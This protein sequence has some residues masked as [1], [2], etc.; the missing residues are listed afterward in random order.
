MAAAIGV[1][2]M[3]FISWTSSA[4]AL[5]YWST[6]HRHL[7]T[8]LHLDDKYSTETGWDCLRLLEAACDCAETVDS[9][10]NLF[11]AP[12]CLPAGA[13]GPVIKSQHSHA[14][15]LQLVGLL[16]LVAVFVLEISAAVKFRQS[17]YASQGYL[18]TSLVVGD[19]SPTLGQPGQAACCTGLHG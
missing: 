12:S 9:R 6:V 2:I 5:G 13:F 8:Y 19:P 16:L 15:W 3:S 18:R 17:A 11:W 10:A 7:A 4:A 1:S 14:W